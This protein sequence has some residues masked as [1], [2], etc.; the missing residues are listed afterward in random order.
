M[1][2]FEYATVYFSNGQEFNK[3]IINV[4]PIATLDE[5]TG[6]ITVSVLAELSNTASAVSVTVTK[7]RWKKLVQ[8]IEEMIE[9]LEKDK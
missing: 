3:D 6:D 9:E 1:S 5:K 7:E 8:E 4:E 2:V